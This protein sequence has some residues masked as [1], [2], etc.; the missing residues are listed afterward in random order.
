MDEE[1]ETDESTPV[2]FVLE[3]TDEATRA[4]LPLCPGPFGGT[5]VLVLADV[6]QTR[7][8]KKLLAID[9]KD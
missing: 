9:A 7:Y 5:T 8:Q 3:P 6:V 2:R 4:A 1:P